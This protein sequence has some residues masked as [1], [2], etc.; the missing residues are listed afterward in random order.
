MVGWC[1][2][3]PWLWACF[4]PFRGVRRLD[5]VRLTASVSCLGAVVC[6]G[7]P[8]C[9]V[10]C[11]AML[12]RAVPRCAAVRPALPSRA[13][14]RRAVVPL[15]VAWRV[16]PCCDA[17]HCVMLCCAVS[18]GAMSRCAAR[19]CVVLRCAVLR[20]VVPCFAAPWCVVSQ[21]YLWPGV[22]WRRRWFDWWLCCLG[23]GLRLYGWPVVAGCGLAWCGLLGLCC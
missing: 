8:C 12:R 7:V 16:A 22:G 3:V 15:A 1:G 13:V 6:F 23:R 19:Q 11:C 4:F 2:V 21:L 18:L 5:L 14:P 9:V 20:R 10:L 17:P